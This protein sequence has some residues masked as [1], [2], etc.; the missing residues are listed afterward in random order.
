MTTPASG[1]PQPQDSTIEVVS[2][3]AVSPHHKA[4]YEAGKAMLVESMHTGREFCRFMITTSSGAIPVY[5]GIM[6]FILPKDYALGLRGSVLVAAPALLFL[7]ASFVFA[8]GYFPSSGSFSLDIL[9]QIERARS[10][11]IRRR[12]RWARLGFLLFTLAALFAIVTIV[13]SFGRR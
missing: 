3:S 6:T 1:T 12:K 9:D 7:L 5:L 2:V 10:T 13:S 8:L 4:L 11:I